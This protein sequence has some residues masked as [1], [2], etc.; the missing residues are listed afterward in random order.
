MAEPERQIEVQLGHLCNN[1]CVFCVSGQLSE[2]KRAPQLPVDPIADQIRAARA[3]GATKVTFLGGEPTIQRS[4]LSLLELAVELDFDEIVIFTNG[5][6]TPRESFRERVQRVLAGLGPR[7]KERVIWRFSLQGGDAEH[8]DETTINP[9]AWERIQRSMEVLKGQGARVTGNMCVVEQNYRSVDKLAGVASRF[10]FE[11]LHLDMVRPRDSGDRTDEQ[12]R[13][14]M[15]RYSDM[16]PY[17]RR[18]VGRCS[19]EIG[20]DFD[21]NIGNMPYCI[22]P[23]ISHKMHHD[24]QFTVTVAASGQGT[25]Q[26]GFNKY[27]DKRSDKVKPGSCA[28]CVFDAKC[29]GIF[30][31]YVE[32]YGLDEFQPVNADALW[33]SPSHPGHFV[34]LAEDAVESWAAERGGDVLRVHERDGY[35]DVRLNA[36]SGRPCVL[37]LSA[38][39]TQADPGWWRRSGE[40]L[41]VSWLSLSLDDA[42]LNWA[43]EA[44]EAL[45]TR[46]G[47]SLATVKVEERRA[48]LQLAQRGHEERLRQTKAARRRAMAWVDRLRGRALGELSYER[49]EAA[50]G[51]GVTLSWRNGEQRVELDVSPDPDGGRPRLEHRAQGL[52]E[53][54]LRRFNV[55]LANALRRRAATP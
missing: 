21:V 54:D 13:A 36:P 34:L 1:R 4:F 23:D 40:R 30:E 43:D 38:A 55:A 33:A 16:A 48:A 24:G 9:G 20:A 51:G 17:F 2:Q 26:Q 52:E 28:D 53:P 45:A 6:M 42:D 41:H 46:L 29:G 12:L 47:G 22:A 31:K 25:T 10:E 15:A 14:M 11:N 35:V 49:L 7:V 5:V 3:S 8:H 50:D 39:P 37:R 32:F 27:L 19:D 18:L 44:C